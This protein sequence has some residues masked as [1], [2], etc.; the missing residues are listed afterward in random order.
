[1]IPRSPHDAPPDS[2]PGSDAGG[3]S[4]S[5]TARAARDSAQQVWLAGLGAFA[6][7]QQEGGK[8]FEAL[9]Q[10]GLALQRRTQSAAQQHLAEAAS[11]VGSA[12]SELGARAAG[13][14][15]QLESVF[16][17]RVATALSRLGVPT[18]RDIQALH[19]RID[20]LTRALEKAQE[21]PRETPRARRAAA[22]QPPRSPRP[23][24]RATRPGKPP[25]GT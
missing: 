3:E 22:A 5:A 15:S 14:W 17:D 10:E 19:E 18:S 24:A 21:S 8:V 23:S 13:S 9:V 12:A 6:K 4:A 1:M 20:A 11:R 7:A 2:G 25:A 16:E